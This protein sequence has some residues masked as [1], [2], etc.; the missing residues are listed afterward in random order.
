MVEEAPNPSSRDEA[1]ASLL[2]FAGGDRSARDRLFDMVY[3]DLK[4][5]AQA[6]LSRENVG[7]TLQPTALVHEVYMRLID[8]SQVDPASKHGFLELAA[9]AMRRILVD[10]ARARLRD[11]R[12]GGRKRVE[13]DEDLLGSSND[14]DEAA[15][16]SI[17]DA[18]TELRGQSERLARLVEMRFFAGLGREEIADVLGV[19]RAT[20]ARDWRVARA[21]LTRILD[22]PETD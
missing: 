3:A 12:G 22:V 10:H 7:H 5:Q 16:L 9:Q 1:T 2:R 19:S 20:V 14:V 15:L 18:L 6:F 4:R 8:S 21:A 13:V 11:K 17:D